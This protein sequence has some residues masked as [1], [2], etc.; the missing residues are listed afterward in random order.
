MRERI[1]SMG[2]AARKS[3]KAPDDDDDDDDEAGGGG[4][5]SS[6]NG[7]AK[8]EAGG[9]SAAAPGTAQ[10][11]PAERPPAAGGAEEHR[12]LKSGTLYRELSLAPNAPWELRHFE[13]TSRATLLC[14]EAPGVVGGVGG[15]AGG[16]GAPARVLIDS[17][18]LTGCSVAVPKTPPAGNPFAFRV[19]LDAAYGRKKVVLAGQSAEES[20]AWQQAILAAGAAAPAHGEAQPPPRPAVPPPRPPSEPPPD[21]LRPDAATREP[22]RK[23]MVLGSTGN[24]GQVRS[25]GVNAVAWCG[26]NSVLLAH[27]YASEGRARGAVRAC[28]DCARVHACMCVRA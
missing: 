23:V 22:K 15:G 27:A 5:G 10:R 8:L 17:L 16:G 25:R 18:P 14:Y 1:A 6:R 11:P 21:F 19:V 3:F 9:P 12:V 24:V 13:V 4:S 26:G 28:G 20:T 2:Q 7:S